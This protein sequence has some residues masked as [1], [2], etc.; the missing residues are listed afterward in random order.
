MP[1]RLEFA[2]FYLYLWPCS[3][4]CSCDSWE[5]I[6]PCRTCLCCSQPLSTQ[7]SA[8]SCYL[9]TLKWRNVKPISSSNIVDRRD[10]DS[11]VSVTLH[12]DHLLPEKAQ[13]AS[14]RSQQLAPTLRTVI[15]IFQQPNKCVLQSNR[16]YCLGLGILIYNSGIGRRI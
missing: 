13:R 1:V 8:T 5:D 11:F 15:G 7:I 14:P 6:A 2:G 9:Q 12:H 16:Q 3:R 10:V 4:W